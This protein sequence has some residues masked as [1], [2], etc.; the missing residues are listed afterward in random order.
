MSKILPEKSVEQ[1]ETQSS[2]IEKETSY[3]GD[4]DSGEDTD[5]RILETE[6][7]NGLGDDFMH[8][9]EGEIVGDSLKPEIIPS[10]K[11][12]TVRATFFR[13]IIDSH[14]D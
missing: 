4:S 11:D 12:D 5:K 7:D 8:D 13:F 2:E 3:D 1:P 6:G 10:K 14:V 9:I